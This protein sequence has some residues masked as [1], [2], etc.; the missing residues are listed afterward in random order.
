MRIKKCLSYLLIIAFIVTMIPTQIFATGDNWTDEGNYTL[1]WL[2]DQHYNDGSIENPYIIHSK[3]DLAAFALEVNSGNFFMGKYIKISENVEIDLSN[4]Y[5]VPIGT[6]VSPF[7]GNFD[8]NNINITG[9]R[10]GDEGNPNSTLEVAG[11]FGCAAVGII[12]NLGV[13]VA[14]YSSKD[15]A[16]IG[17]VVGVIQNVTIENCYTT[18][19]ITGGDYSLVGGLLGDMAASTIRNSC[20][21]VNVTSGNYS[22][23]GGLLG[24]CSNST[25]QNSFATGTIV[26]GMEAKVGGLLGNANPVSCTI[27]SSYWNTSSAGQAFGNGAIDGITGMYEYEFNL[28]EFLNTLNTNSVSG[29]TDYYRWRKDVEVIEEQRNK[30]NGFPFA[31]SKHFSTITFDLNGGTGSAPNVMNVEPNEKFIFQTSEAGINPPSGKALKSWNVLSDGNGTSY[32]NNYVKKISSG[33]ILY[34]IYGAISWQ[35]EDNYD[36]ALYSKLTN[37]TQ[38]QNIFD[39]GGVLEITNAREFGAFAKATNDSL[40][41]TNYLAY[42][43]TEYRDAHDSALPPKGSIISVKL[44]DNIDLSGLYWDGIASYKTQINDAFGFINFDGNNKTISNLSIEKTV[45]VGLSGLFGVLFASKVKNLSVQGNITGNSIYNGGITCILANS[46]IENCMSDVDIAINTLSFAGG[47][48]VLEMPMINP[49]DDEFNYSNITNCVNKGDI[50]VPNEIDDTL[51]TGICGPGNSIK[52]NNCY[53]VGTITANYN[54][55]IGIMFEG[56]DNY[57]LD[58]ITLNHPGMTEGTSKTQEY[59]KSSSFTDDLN[60][61]VYDNNVSEPD[62]YS[63]WVTQLFDYPTFEWLS[64]ANASVAIDEIAEQPI[65]AVDTQITVP[66]KSTFDKDV[67]LQ[68]IEYKISYNNQVFDVNIDDYIGLTPELTQNGTLSTLTITKPFSDLLVFANDTQIIDFKPIIKSSAMA[69]EQLITLV[70]IIKILNNSE[71]LEYGTTQ[72]PIAVTNGI[73]N[74]TKSSYSSGAVMNITDMID[75]LNIDKTEI[76]APTTNYDGKVVL[77]NGQ[78]K[79]K[80]PFATFAN[81]PTPENTGSLFGNITF[82]EDVLSFDSIEGTSSGYTGA[83]TGAGNIR[84]TADYTNEDLKTDLENIV[85]NFTLKKTPDNFITSITSNDFS[86]TEKDQYGIVDASR[87]ENLAQTPKTQTI[88]FVEKNDPTGEITDNYIK[89]VLNESTAEGTTNKTFKYPDLSLTSNKDI[90]GARVYITDGFDVSDRIGYN[91]NYNSVQFVD[92]VEIKVTN[93]GRVITLTGTASPQVYQDILNK[94]SIE[95]VNTNVER[96]VVFEAY[97]PN[98]TV[99]VNGTKTNIVPFYNPDNGHLY[100]YVPNRNVTWNNALTLASQRSIA[101]MTGYLATITNAEENEIIK[102]LCAGEGWLGGSQDM[103]TLNLLLSKN[104]TGQGYK[105]TSDYLNPNMSQGKWFWVTGPEAGQQFYKQTAPE[106]SANLAIP[107]ISLMYTNWL[108]TYE[109]NNYYNIGENYLHIYPVNGKWNDYTNN[110]SGIGG[111][112]VEYGGLET[113]SPSAISIARVTTSILNPNNDSSTLQIVFPVLPTKVNSGYTL[114]LYGA[115][116]TTYTWQEVTSTNTLENGYRLVNNTGASKTI[117]IRATGAMI[118]A[119]TTTKDYEITVVASN[120]VI[121][122]PNLYASGKNA[123]VSLSWEAVSDASY[124]EVYY[125]IADGGTYNSE[126]VIANGPTT[127]VTGL[128]N[129]TEY[130]FKIVAALDN[131]IKSLQ[132]DEV[133]ATPIAPS[134]NITGITV[135][136]GETTYPLLPNFNIDETNYIV[137]IPSDVL[138]VDITATKIGDGDISITNNGV[139]VDVNS[140]ATVTID[141]ENNSEDNRTYTITFVKVYPKLLINYTY[142]NPSSS[143]DDGCLNL[144]G[145][146]GSSHGYQYSINGGEDWYDINGFV[147]LTEGTYLLQ[148]KDDANNYSEI[149]SATLITDNKLLADIQFFGNTLYENDSPQSI[150]YSVSNDLVETTDYTVTYSDMDGMIIEKPRYEGTYSITVTINADQPYYYGTATEQFQII[151]L[152]APSIV[153]GDIIAPEGFRVNIEIGYDPAITYYHSGDTHQTAK[154]EYFTD[155]DGWTI[156]GGNSNVIQIASVFINKELRYTVSTYQTVDGHQTPTTTESKTIVLKPQAD[157]GIIVIPTVQSVA[158][159]HDDGNDSEITDVNRARH[160]GTLKAIPTITQ[161]TSGVVI[162]ETYRWFIDGELVDDAINST[163]TLQKQD[164]GKNIAA[165]VAVK[166]DYNALQYFTS[167]EDKIVYADLNMAPNVTASSN[168]K[169]FGVGKSISVNFSVSEYYNIA[170]DLENPIIKSE[171]TSLKYGVVTNNDGSLDVNADNNLELDATTIDYTIANDN[172]YIIFKIQATETTIG[173]QLAVKT[174]MLKIDTYTGIVTNWV[175][176]LDYVV[177]DNANFNGYKVYQIITNIGENNTAKITIDPSKISNDE[178]SKMYYSPERGKYVAIMPWNV[179]PSLDNVII[180][181]GVTDEIFYGKQGNTT[182][183]LDADDINKPIQVWLKNTTNGDNTNLV[184]TEVAGD[185]VIDPNDAAQIGSAI[186]AGNVKA[187]RFGIL[188]K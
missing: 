84:V 55:P 35:D 135:E 110:Q 171:I 175:Y 44:M 53:N 85:L 159:V 11:L 127:D 72:Y 177:S 184:L 183:E 61:W 102:G 114:P 160:N 113:D 78:I 155:G 29:A 73:V 5:W 45:E 179:E 46:D 105:Y 58:S 161:D 178:K 154:W 86:L 142:R 77:V 21:N 137:T 18:G 140:Q 108:P 141:S 82:D 92:G 17:G 69:G 23:V 57:Y 32:R 163:Y 64:N 121:P 34:A 89:L 168:D 95:L 7:C 119:Q 12:K 97:N 143:N 67:V 134:T 15:H 49:L 156:V 181:L 4:F 93:G 162:G 48:A 158:L 147:N 125:K 180:E 130:T 167:S 3:F 128:D 31:T 37:I 9:L 76:P 173:E 129:G 166:T 106:S 79:I 24:H 170:E 118:G 145:F 90:M 99:V 122:Q 27:T 41:L 70:P 63:L 165:M 66:I 42:A 138:T 88:Y 98:S 123:K 96:N 51:A 115:N 124:Y 152:K 107:G 87:K 2:T 94:I 139:G 111:Y 103:D 117:T 74:L 185:G 6:G 148:I 16:L 164:V 182:G 153:I 131:A 68:S 149:L 54:F 47:I 188:S 62:K 60:Q 75:A 174:C 133:N 50:Q 172:R 186:L 151:K 22:N 36:T 176:K 126:P 146:G 40:E 187:G 43:I 101:G 28:N 100:E 56:S 144:F 120:I 81:L 109:P 59:L 20:S 13:D 83:R 39:N 1:N 71:V 26:G 112:V 91:D 10:I 116:S 104:F 8:G 65:Q 136:N 33:I 150:G 132:S 38:I 52:I 14:I 169:E 80:V 19:T 30:N 25:I 157:G